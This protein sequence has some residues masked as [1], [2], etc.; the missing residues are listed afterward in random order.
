MNSP[1]QLAIGVDIGGTKI[2]FALVD[3][4]GNIQQTLRLPTPAAA[5]ADAVIAAII[6][7]IEHLRAG[8]V[9]A[10]IV[11]IGIGCPGHVDAAAGI[12]RYAVNLNWDEVPV[13]ELVAARL[14]GRLPVVIENDVRAAA[15]GEMRYGA[16]RGAR[17]LAYLALGTGLGAAAVVDGH[18]FYGA[19]HFAME[20]GQI[21]RLPEW[22]F[23]DEVVTLEHI[24]SGPGLVMLA[25]WLRPQYPG[26]ALLESATT[27][28]VIDAAAAGD[29]L[30][31]AAVHTQGEW[32]GRAVVWIASIL[33]PELVVIGGGAGQ[34]ACQWLLP[35]VES[36]I[37]THCSPPLVAMIEVKC[38]TLNDPS[39]GAAS[40]VWSILQK[41]EG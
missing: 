29:P 39:L 40:L 3:H 13:R 12:V 19:A 32:L 16:A 1:G 14:P 36:A 24:L 20:A 18:L 6:Q 2:A 21:R 15:L 27:Y 35:A 5:G 11:G 17:N 28:D 26:S 23:G 33:N 25:R 31:L 10:E 4:Q 41:S 30:A 8:S 38:S 37:R 7:G 22:P 34:A 9:E